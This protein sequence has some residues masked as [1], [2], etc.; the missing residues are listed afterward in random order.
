ML[1]LRFG[2]HLARWLD[3]RKN[4][5]GSSLRQRH[6]HEAAKLLLLA[7]RFDRP[8]Y[9]FVTMREDRLARLLGLAV[10]GA[11]DASH[12]AELPRHV[13]VEVERIVD[14]LAACDEG[15]E[16]LRI[17]PEHQLLDVQAGAAK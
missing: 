4:V 14:V 3:G 6:T 5:K 12:D 11:Q 1:L 15:Q 13:L 8:A 10:P 7:H 9:R 2:V 16:R 17:D